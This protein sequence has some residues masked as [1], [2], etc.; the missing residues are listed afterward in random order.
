MSSH[1]SPLNGIYPSG[2]LSINDSEVEVTELQTFPMLKSKAVWKGSVIY[3]GECK[4]YMKKID[5]ATQHV[6]SYITLCSKPGH[7]RECELSCFESLG[8]S[9]LDYSLSLQ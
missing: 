5:T 3:V 4:R 8:I 1:T 2:C 6:A 9:F 7:L